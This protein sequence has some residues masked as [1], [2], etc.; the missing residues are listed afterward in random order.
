M[1]GDEGGDD[2]PGNGASNGNDVTGAGPGNK[3]AY[4][5]GPD[6]VSVETT[7]RN[8]QKTARG[9]CKSPGNGINSTAG[10]SGR[11]KDIPIPADGSCEGTGDQKVGKVTPL[12]GGGSVPTEK[13]SGPDTALSGNRTSDSCNVPETGGGQDTG[14]SPDDCPPRRPVC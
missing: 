9:L 12:T 4:N 6:N 7:G 1:P 8:N 10:S 5:C 13:V 2:G 14:E 3:P 11:L